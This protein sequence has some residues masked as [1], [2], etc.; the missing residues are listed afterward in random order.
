M[1]TGLKLT[2]VRP[3]PENEINHQQHKRRTVI[4]YNKR[5]DLE[6]SVTCIILALNFHCGSK[7]L[8]VRLVERSLIAQLCNLARTLASCSYEHSQ[9]NNQVQ[10]HLSVSTCAFKVRHYWNQQINSLD[11]KS[12]TGVPDRYKRLNVWMNRHTPT[13]P[14]NIK[15]DDPG[16]YKTILCELIEHSTIYKNPK[17][18]LHSFDLHFYLFTALT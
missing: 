11:E 18:A 2:L 7:H 17:G 14:A 9:P 5:T 1:L 3:K 4:N 13:I 16:K 8:F 12:D 6:R 15:T 10:A